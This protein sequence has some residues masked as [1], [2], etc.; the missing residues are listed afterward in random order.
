MLLIFA[1]LAFFQIPGLIKKKYWKELIAF[2]FFYTFAFVLSFL[3]V[4]DVAIPSP[5]KGVRYVIED[6]LKI[7]Y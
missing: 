6:L 3:Y 5:I 1:L 4:L 7:K 2:S